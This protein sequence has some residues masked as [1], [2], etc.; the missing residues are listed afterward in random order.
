MI[1]AIVLV[2]AAVLALAVILRIAVSQRLQV[3][4]GASFTG[5]IQAI[6]VEAFRNL[7]DPA[8]E[9]YLRR[10]LPPSK[11]RRP[12]GAFRAMAA[13]V[14][15]A[16]AN[17]SVLVRIGQAALAAGNPRTAMP[18]G[19]WST[20]RCCCAEMPRWLSSGYTSNCRGR[21]MVWRRWSRRSL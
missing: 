17:A 1:L 3:A 16:A 18:Q 14:Q 2:L 5:Q 19:S 12:K 4:R 21:A 8:E 10:R 11:S 15:I 6:D 7:A 9:Q 13:Y 20:T